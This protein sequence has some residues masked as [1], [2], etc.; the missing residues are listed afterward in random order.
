MTKKKI[1]IISGKQFSG[2]DS[3]ATILSEALPDFQRVA[4]ADALKEEL[5]NSKNI[6][7][8]EIDMN[9]TLYRSE[10][11]ELGQR[12]R[13]EDKDYWINV[14]LGSEDNIIVTD[15]RLKREYEIFKDLGAISVRIES[16]LEERQKR[17]HISQDEDI[18]ETDLDNLQTWDY[19]IHNNSDFETLKQKAQDVTKSIEK[20]V[21]SVN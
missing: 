14:V 16:D 15:V 4:L 19:V 20:T 21:Y 13:A 12:R 8:K 10:L 3:V 1:V 5:G 9:K 18:T 6:S 17:G 7:I 2:K 11:I